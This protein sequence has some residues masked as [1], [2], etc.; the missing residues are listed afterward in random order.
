MTRDEII[1]RAKDCV[2][3]VMDDWQRDRVITDETTFVDLGC[4]SIDKTSI[5]MEIEDEF[6]IYIDETGPALAITNFA[7]L[8]SH[9]EALL[10]EKEKS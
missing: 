4:D 2:I 1:I 3:T 7:G 5:L 9:I 6:D 10:A 8:I